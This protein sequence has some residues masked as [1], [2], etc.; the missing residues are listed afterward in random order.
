MKVIIFSDSHAETKYMLKALNFFENEIDAIIHLGDYID[1]TKVI[2][3]NFPKKQLY[4]V[5][6]N[7]DFCTTPSEKTIKI[8]RY[9]LFIT[10]GHNYNPY[11]GADR[12]Y[13]KGSEV[14]ADIVLYGH[15]HTP[16]IFEE[17]ILI[18]NPGSVAFPRS[19][20]DKT[21]L[22]MNLAETITYEIYAIDDFDIKKLDVN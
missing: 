2:K 17:D 4:A 19:F 10:H 16:A 7:N 11:N 14:G 9:T 22:I 13:Y 18:I 3:S 1:D 5:A 20:P 21:F 8:G 6:G 12:L 15:T